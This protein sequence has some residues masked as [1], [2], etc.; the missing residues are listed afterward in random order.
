MDNRAMYKLSYGLYVLSVRSGE[1]DNGCIVN[2]A[3][4]VTS[5]PNQIVVTVNKLNYT[6]KLLDET[7]L[8]NLSVLSVDAD[9]SLFQNFGFQSGAT[10]D[11][12]A[13]Q[14][15]IKRSENGILYLDKSA[16]SFLSGKVTER[17]D[18]GT[19]IMYVADVTAAE[20]LNDRPS[21]TYEYYHA[22][23]KP[24][25]AQPSGKAGQWKCNICGYIYEG[26]ELPPDFICPICKHGAV[27]FTQIR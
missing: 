21:M 13:A 24:A 9:F 25:S 22:N 10:T 17:V 19:H 11:K 12:F 23:V 15:D 4:Q 7:G 6:G 5:S 18:V 3:M 16:N 2:T 26:D 27:D 20:V 14:K 1:K 8:F